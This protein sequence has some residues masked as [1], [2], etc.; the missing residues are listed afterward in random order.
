MSSP[1]R[2][3]RMRNRRARQ[4]ARWA[5]RSGPVVTAQLLAPAPL[6]CGG[7]PDP[8]L[9]GDPIALFRPTDPAGKWWGHAECVAASRQDRAM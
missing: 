1:A 8:V 2:Q 4:N 3:A 7:C 9:P 6:E 5:A